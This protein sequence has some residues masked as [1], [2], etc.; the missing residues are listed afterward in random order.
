MT[1]MGGDDGLKMGTRW[2]RGIEGIAAIGGV[3]LF[4]L[5]LIT[6]IDIVG[7]NAGL[8]Y[9][10]G[11]IEFSTGTVV[12]LG[13]LGLAHCFNQGGH[14]V[15][16]LATQNTSRHVNQVLDIMWLAV[17]GLMYAA[18][19]WLMW[20]D[21]MQRHLTGEVTDNLEWSPLAFTVPAVLGAAVAALTCLGMTVRGIVGIRRGRGI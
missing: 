16:D 6:V 2:T 14:I 17:A 3:A 1:A 21:G 11:V 8:F 10:Q 12:F 18:M 20:D 7:R 15:V 4:G 9:L 13:F 5:M 19:A